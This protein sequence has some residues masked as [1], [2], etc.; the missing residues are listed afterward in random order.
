MLRIWKL[1]VVVLSV[2]AW[3]STDGARV[4]A[5]SE[6]KGAE[7]PPP[8]AVPGSADKTQPASGA[9][10]VPVSVAM[11]GYCPVCIKDMK[12]WVMGK[13]EI[14]AS[15]QGRTYYF[16][17]EKQK[18]VFQANPAK[19]APV[20]GGECT[21]CKVEMGKQVSGNIRFGTFY[22]NQLYLFENDKQKSMFKANPAKYEV[23]MPTAGSDTKTA[24][25]AAG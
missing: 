13:P 12:K 23:V 9:R 20:S 16:P 11:E 7:Q 18:K 24:P 14:N 2:A 3:T 4:L 17:G 19:Y 6:T 22:K 25:D 10:G 21:V 5:Q 15:Y 8:A 1:A